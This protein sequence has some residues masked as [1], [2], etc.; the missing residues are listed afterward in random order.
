ME[1]DRYDSVW[2]AVCDTPAE[3]DDMK[4]RSELMMALKAHIE[5]QG[6]TTQEAAERLG[7]TLPRL[8]ELL[9]GRIDRFSLDALRHITATVAL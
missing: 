4:R 7:M 1:H 2:D 3:A 9:A 8:D 6:W 5:R